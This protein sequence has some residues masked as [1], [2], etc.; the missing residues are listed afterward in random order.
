MYLSGPL[1]G[2]KG[3]FEIYDMSTGGLGITSYS[4]DEFNEGDVIRILDLS[5]KPP[6]SQLLGKVVSIVQID[7]ETNEYKVGVQFFSK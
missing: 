3:V 6:A 1:E 7:K 2:K 5:G 4:E